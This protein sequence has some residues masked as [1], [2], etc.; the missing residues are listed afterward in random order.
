[1]TMTPEEWLG[2]GLT[3]GWCGPPCCVPHDGVGTTEAEDDEYDDGGDPC[4]HVLRLYS[5]LETRDAVEANHSPSVWRK[6]EVEPPPP[7]LRLIKG[8]ADG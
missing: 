1:M 8:A 7:G 2:I 5:D 4:Y 6:R 3:N